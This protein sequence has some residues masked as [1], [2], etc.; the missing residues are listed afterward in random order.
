M[1]WQS[2]GGAMR[3]LYTAEVTAVGGRE[4]RVRSS[5]GALTM[6]LATPKELGGPGG[7]AT[8]PEQLFAAGYAA[9]FENAVRHVG[10]RRKLQVGEASVT[11]R[12]GIGPTGDGGFGLSA[13]LHVRLPDLDANVA[14]EIVAEADRVC[15]YSNAVRGNIDVRVLVDSAP[16]VI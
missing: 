6:E 10:R 7:V 12:V 13:E 8:N 5:D 4:G 15:P 9:C 2:G 16:E 3:V 1:R 11:A 14:E